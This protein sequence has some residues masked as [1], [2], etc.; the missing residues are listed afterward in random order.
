MTRRVAVLSIA[1]SLASVLA[2]STP[3]ATDGDRHA[4]SQLAFG[5][6]VPAQQQ[7]E[8]PPS[9]WPEVERLRAELWATRQQLARVRTERNQLRDQLDQA[10][11]VDP[12]ESFQAGYLAG[13]GSSLGAIM[14]IAQCES[15]LADPT[16]DNAGLNRNGTT[17]F[18]YLQINDGVWAD[19]FEEVTGQPFHPHVGDPYW[20]G[21]M[22]AH[23]EQTQGWS[24][25][26]ASRHCHGIR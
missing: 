7:T 1:A 26:S 20:N 24:A 4:P 6:S 2:T 3:H 21:Y 22:G 8:D 19:R 14:Q 5:S 25:W 18:G 11:T 13:G 10:Q 12:V 9:L 23:I 17:D 16:I 15:G